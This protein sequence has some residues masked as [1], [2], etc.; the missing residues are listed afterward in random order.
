LYF[1]Y[2][3]RLSRF[4][5]RVVRRHDIAEEI[6][7]DTMF[8]VWRKAGNFRGESRVSTWVL[9]IAYRQALK[10]L[11]HHVTRGRKA[12]MISID[13]EAND[14]GDDAGADQ[15]ELRQWIDRGLEALPPAQRL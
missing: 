6:I 15:R 4:L 12:V 1:N 9:G 5:L 8:T 2:Y 7:N 14:L 10:A 3:R 11:E 13:Q